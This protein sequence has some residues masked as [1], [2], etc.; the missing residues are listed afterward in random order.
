MQNILEDCFSQDH[1]PH[2]R[3]DRNPRDHQLVMATEDGQKNKESTMKDEAMIMDLVHTRMARA[4]S[5]LE[6]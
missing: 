3:L 4:L 5:I 6:A 2:L 1:L